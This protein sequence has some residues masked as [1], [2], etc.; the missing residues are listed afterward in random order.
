MGKDFRFLAM[1]Y[2]PGIQ[3]GSIMFS[4]LSVIYKY[5]RRSQVVFSYLSELRSCTLLI[6][7]PFNP[8]TSTPKKVIWHSPI[9][10][11]NNNFSTSCRCSPLYHYD[12]MNYKATKLFTNRNKTC[13]VLDLYWKV[14]L[15]NCLCR[16]KYFGIVDPLNCCV[17]L[18]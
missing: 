4:A 14:I 1:F 15:M 17:F 6:S 10:C 3:H 12:I 7:R 18:M 9:S 5:E 11:K 13:S 2:A 16:I 8:F